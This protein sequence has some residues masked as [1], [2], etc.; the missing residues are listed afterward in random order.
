MI[1]C[2]NNNNN[3]GCNNTVIKVSGNNAAIVTGDNSQAATGD[4]TSIAVNTSASPSVAS[5]ADE[6]ARIREQ[7]SARLDDAR[8][9]RA[10]AELEIAA[11]NN[12]TDSFRKKACSYIKDLSVPFFARIASYALICAIHA[13]KAS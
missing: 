4:G 10:V 3:V 8:L 1:N 12:D 11:R 7:L 2:N 13:T 6:L 5:F 9:Y